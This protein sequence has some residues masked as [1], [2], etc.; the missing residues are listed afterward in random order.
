[1][2]RAWLVWLKT[3]FGLGTGDMAQSLSDRLEGSLN[4]WS[5]LEGT[6]LLTL[7]LFFGTIALVDLRM[8]GL[9][10]RGAPYSRVSGKLLG[11]TV[12]GF[13]IVTVTGLA[14]FFAKPLDY[15]HN[16]FFRLKMV[17]IVLALVN[18]VVFHLWLQRDLP[19]WDAA[20]VAPAAVRIA[21]GLSL[22]LWILVIACGRY[23]P[24]TWFA[25]GHPIAAWMNR[26]EDCAA[27]EAG[28]VVAEAK[29]P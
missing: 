3:Q 20:P 26:F 11:L 6:H 5:L 24:Q 22:T 13:V 18:M 8:L 12:A 29:A 19:R 1:V 21:G 14:L 23:I 4:F 7:M 16:I 27:S 25:C 2:I 9:V 15:Y 10:F 17:L 28:A